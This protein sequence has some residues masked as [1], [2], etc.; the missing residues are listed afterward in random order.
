MLGLRVVPPLRG[1]E[2]IRIRVK[3]VL[4][5]VDLP[6]VAPV[7]NMKQYNGAY[8]CPVCEQSGN[9]RPNCPMVRDWPK[10]AAVSLRS[11]DSIVEAV[12]EGLRTNSVVSSFT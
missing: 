4:L 12:R 1:S 2:P 8:G 5:S 9:P 11:Q 6:A 10:E 7:L 3:L